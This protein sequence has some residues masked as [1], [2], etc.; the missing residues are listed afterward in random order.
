M[1][2]LTV[3]L[4]VKVVVFAGVCAA[5]AIVM[6][7]QS[8]RGPLPRSFA[9]YLNRD[10]KMPAADQTKLLQGLPVTRL[11][12]ADPSTEV[13]IFG[14]V[15]VNAPITR[16]V[17]AVKDIEN[18]EKGDNF[19]VTKKISSPPQLEDFAQLT[20]PQEDFDDL[21]SC[22]VGSCEVKLG[23][24]ALTKLQREVDWSKPGA[25]ADVDR[26]MR[27]LALDYVNAYLEGGNVR[28]AEYRD[29]DRPRF[30]GKEFESMVDRMPS[31]GVYLPDIRRYLVGF[32][33]VSLPASTSFLY[34]QEAKFGLK[35]TIRINHV[36]IVEEP[37]RT[38][39]TSKMLYASHYFWTALELRVLVPDPSRGE[40]FWFACVNRSRSDGLSGFVGS[41][42]R[43]KVRSE[44][45]KGM[46]AALRATKTMLE[47]RTP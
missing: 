44:A 28:L 41:M 14:A 7:R 26:A 20:L 34:W 25:K 22:K 18:F 5:S 29:S 11:L 33:N 43:G 1:R 36:T 21:R 9:D 32:P 4:A 27:A 46:Q 3:R 13:A 47:D 12:D 15:W 2:A 40:G 8:E 6:A 17:A 16:Y 42:L 45:E 38:V 24:A 19:L 39:M 35:P 23:Q 31:L 10:V 30:T 37:D